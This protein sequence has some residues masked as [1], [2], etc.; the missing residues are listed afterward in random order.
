MKSIVKPGSSFA[1]VRQLDGDRERY[2]SSLLI[3]DKCGGRYFGQVDS[4]TD[5]VLDAKK[6]DYLIGFGISP[7]STKGSLRGRLFCKS[8]QFE[9]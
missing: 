9:K 8:R 2:A 1:S 3:V 5:P 7:D 6:I 4:V